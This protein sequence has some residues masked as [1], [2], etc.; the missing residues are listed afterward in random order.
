MLLDVTDLLSIRAAHKG[1]SLQIDQSSEFPRYIVAD[2]AKLRQILINLISNAIKATDQG[3]VKV[4]LGVKHHGKELHLIIDVKDTGCGIAEDDQQKL[5]QPFVQVGP[6]AGQQGT[7]LGLAISR[8][9]AELMGGGISVTSRI[10]AG[11]TFHVDVVVQPARPEEMPGVQVE[12]G[13]VTGLEADQPLWR[14]LVVEDQLDNQRLLVGLLEQVGFQVR[15]AENGAAA[16][17]EFTTWQPHFIWMDRR[18]PVMDG[19]E[20]TRRIRALP[21]GAAVKIAAVTAST[22]REEDA[23]LSMAGFD[24]VVHKPYRP[25][26]IFDCMERLLGARF[27]RTERPDQPDIPAQLSTFA[28]QDLPEPLYRELDDALLLLD[29]ARILRAI[30]AISETAPELATALGER[31]SHYDYTGIRKALKRRAS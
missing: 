20:A 8:Q 18:M 5:F 24:A 3:S 17:E 21:D 27:E 12:R 26:Q 19:V 11:S 2:E 13:D 28:L 23:Q 31:A 22:F 9:F 1:V 7:G 10:G 4:R 16:L 15:L 29:S 14:V 6:Q 25:A 30:A